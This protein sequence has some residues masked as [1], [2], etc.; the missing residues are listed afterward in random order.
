MSELEQWH[1]RFGGKEWRLTPEG[2]EVKEEGHVRTEGPPLTMTYLWEDFGDHFLSASRK[3]DC[4]VD[5]PAAMVPIEAARKQG[6]LRF[7]PESVREEPGFESDEETPHKV[8]PGLMQTLIS[9]ARRMADKYDLVDSKKVDREFLFEAE[10]SILL[11]MAYCKDRI[12]VYGP[13]PILICGA[14]NA[15]SVRETDDSEWRIETY[16]PT[17]MDKYARYFNDFH[18][19]VRTGRIDLPEDV[20]TSLP[21]LE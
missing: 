11:G 14:Y 5:I 1:R 7:D 15:G 20:K 4:P 21:G 18:A 2:I 8:S 19:A 6:S 12:E 13:D 17:R 9:T 16:S 3:L 10:H